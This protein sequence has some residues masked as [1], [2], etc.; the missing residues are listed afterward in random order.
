M[1]KRIR[2]VLF[3]T[4]MIV[5][6]LT[7]AIVSQAG[8]REAKEAYISG[9]FAVALNEFI[10][11]ADKGNAE[12]EYHLG[13]MYDKGQGVAQDYRAAASWYRKAADWG[14]VDAQFNL[15]VMY[16]KG[17]GV[18]KDYI[19][20]ARW[21]QKAA[22][23]GDPE[24][25][26]Y[27]GAMYHKG[28]GV[29]QD[30]RS[31][32][33]WYKKAADQGNAQAQYNLGTMYYNGDEVPQD[34]RSALL[35][36]KKA[37]EQ[38]DAQAQYNLGLMLESG[39]GVPQD[40]KAATDWYRKAAEK[41]LVD[42]QF[43]LGTKYLQGQGVTQNYEEA[44]IWFK[45]AAEQG[46]ASSRYNLG[47]MYSTGQGVHTDLIQAYRWL[48]LAEAAGHKSASDSRKKL[49]AMMTPVQIEQAKSTTTNKLLTPSPQGIS[50]SATIGGATAGAILSF[51]M[52]IL[53]F[54]RGLVCFL[55]GFANIP[56]FLLWQRGLTQNNRRTRKVAVAI[57]WFGQSLASIVVILL[58]VA[59]SHFL[60][61]RINIV[62][63][64]KVFYWVFLL[65]VCV[66][67]TIRTLKTALKSESIINAPYYRVTLTLTSATTVVV[68]IGVLFF[69]HS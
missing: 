34:Y 60:F 42:A 51:C 68:F 2:N 1:S 10:R 53:L 21:F 44:A 24:A 54:T 8:L 65:Y 20:A 45:K 4:C 26:A 7:Y 13:V 55:L 29:P 63:L 47:L 25:Q 32:L 17:T 52:L 57:G 67:P 61:T 12:A 38:G 37:A 41:Q 9:N 59:L 6:L 16:I 58:L 49:E 39:E 11:L 22:N 19:E 36:Y 50:G 15:G 5:A 35:W 64:L 43:R 46:S 23:Q 40:Y 3:K 48:F 14:D 66:T 18:E 31:A 28:Y 56:G 62:P 33:L 30:Y 69:M 27:M